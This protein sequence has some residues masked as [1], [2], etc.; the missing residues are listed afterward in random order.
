MLTS[1]ENLVDIETIV[2]YKIK[3]IEQ[4]MFNVNGLIET[5]R[6]IAESQI[7]RVIASHA[8]DEA[9]RDN[10]SD[11]LCSILGFSNVIINM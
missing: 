8:L 3:N 10:K 11:I 7:R 1:D 2:Q 9:L 5:L 6:I 4:Y